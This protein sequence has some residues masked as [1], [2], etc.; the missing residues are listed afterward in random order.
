MTVRQSNSIKVGD[1]DGV[2]ASGTVIY[3]ATRV[4]TMMVP[5]LVEQKMADV[6]SK[7]RLLCTTMLKHTWTQLRDAGDCTS[8]RPLKDSTATDYA[9]F[10]RPD[11]DKSNIHQLHS[12]LLPIP[13]SD[14]GICLHRLF[15]MSL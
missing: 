12:R 11:S 6:A 7:G 15:A 1:E 8:P 10:R 13:K 9:V 3:T 2:Q 14:L 5:R 4:V